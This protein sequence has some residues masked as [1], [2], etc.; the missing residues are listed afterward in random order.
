MRGRSRFRWLWGGS[1]LGGLRG[2]RGQQDVLFCMF[3]LAP[4]VAALPSGYRRV[5]TRFPAADLRVFFFPCMT[6]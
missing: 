1:R 5:R 4:R 3:C 6:V 2:R